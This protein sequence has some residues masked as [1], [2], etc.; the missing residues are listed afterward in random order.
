M[1]P[2][3]YLMLI[4][5]C[6]LGFAPA[7]SQNAA[8]LR[9]EI[10]FNK[11]SS[12]VF[13]SSIISIDRGSPDVLA[14]KAKKVKNVLQ[15]KA[16]KRNFKETN[17]S[18][19]TGDGRLHE[20]TVTYKEHPASIVTRIDSAGAVTV[21][22]V[23]PEDL[24]FHE[25]LTQD[26]MEVSMKRIIGQKGRTIRSRELNKMKFSLK[27]IFVQDDVMYY[28]LTVANKSNISY[29][30]NSLRFYIEDKKTV[31]RT[32]SQQLE[33]IPL[34]E[35]GDGK[36]EIPGKTKTDLVFALSKFTIPGAQKLVIELYEK[37]GG[38]HLTLFVSNRNIVNARVA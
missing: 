11:T 5:F 7:Y 31:K 1:K 18:V 10:T 28:H 29:E 32:A 4:V 12:I 16:A 36:N 3:N 33:I 21:S 9:L 22:A 35:Y 17:L 14:Q 37:N 34:S 24:Q 13:P 30:V 23:I 27:G 2:M 15:V 8:S 26:E 19:I 6:L 38:R 25:S 20:F